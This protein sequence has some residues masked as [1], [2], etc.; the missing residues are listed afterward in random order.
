MKKQHIITIA[1]ILVLGGLGGWKTWAYLNPEEAKEQGL[2]TTEKV[3]DTKEFNNSS[4]TTAPVTTKALDIHPAVPVNGTYKGVIEVGASGF[5]CFVANIDKD[6]N[7]EL[8]SKTFGE[9][10]AYEGFATT[11]DVYEQMKKYIAIIAEKGVAGRNI[12]FVMSSG[13][14]KNPKNQLIAQA[15]KEKGFVVNKVDADQEG[16]YALKA[17]LGK[18][19]RDNSFTVDIGS[20]NTK[21][22]W[23][24]NGKVTSAEASGAKYYQDG[25]KDPDV[26]AEI[27]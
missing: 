8:V 1:I 26:Y 20:G 19:F 27:K 12:H 23:M 25:K 17:L 3:S 14:L 21:I 7:W 10:L 18:D 11:A 15:I 22:S 6:K 5:N 4:T 16:K 9:S 2:V 13:A 24:E